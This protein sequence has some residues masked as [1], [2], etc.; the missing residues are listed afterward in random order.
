MSKDAADIKPKFVPMD[1][2]MPRDN[3]GG[4]NF[5]SHAGEFGDGGHVTG[6][7]SYLSA[8]GGKKDD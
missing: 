8:S 3:S 7:K 5:P 1:A 4:P 6:P 2:L